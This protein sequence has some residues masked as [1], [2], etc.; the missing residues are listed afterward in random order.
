MVSVFLSRQ[1]NGDVVVVLLCAAKVLKLFD[2]DP[3]GFSFPEMVVHL[4]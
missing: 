1:D 4:S 2:L 3:L